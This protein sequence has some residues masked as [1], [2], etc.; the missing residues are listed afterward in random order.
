[1]IDIYATNITGLKINVTAFQ[2]DSCLSIH[3]P[4]AFSQNN[5][6]CFATANNIM[7]GENI[8]NIHR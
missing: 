8:I 3:S 4:D 1:M 7:K 2:N 6:V 5:F